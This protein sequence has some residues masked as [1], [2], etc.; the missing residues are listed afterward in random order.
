MTNCRFRMR[1]IGTTGKSLKPVQPSR[2]KYSAFAVGQISGFSPRVS[3]DERAGVKLC[4][5]I[6]MATVARKPVHRGEREVSRKTTAQG[7]PDA[8]AEPVCSCA[9]SFVHFAH[10]TAGAACTRSSL[11]P[12]FLNEGG[13]FGQ[14]SGTS[15]RE[16]ADACPSIVMPRECG[17]IQYAAACRLK[18]WPLWNTGS[19]GQAGRRHRRAF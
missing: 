4:G 18:Q 15:C 7:R 14:T 17:G 1:Q 13:S 9:F 16:N 19:P 6:R 2:K 11:R 8:S 5:S 10:E 12:L 3:P